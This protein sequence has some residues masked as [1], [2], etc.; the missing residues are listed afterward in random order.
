MT[1]GAHWYVANTQPHREALAMEN[2]KRQG[3]EVYCPLI[4]KQIRHA[5]KVQTV[6]RP[7]FPSYVFVKADKAATRWRAMLST[8]GVRTVIQAGE[9]PAALDNAFVQALKTREIDGV[10]SKPSKPF[11]V[12]E[13]IRIS[14]GAM[15][16]CVASIVQLR[17][18]E[19]LIVLLDL[20]NQSVKVQIHAGIVQPT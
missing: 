4:S 17:D 9:Q 8:L 19:R 2:L 1:C 20:L 15:D 12:G 16:G 14:G 10:I 13:K 5:R 3:Y 11:K 18:K 6:K 7:L